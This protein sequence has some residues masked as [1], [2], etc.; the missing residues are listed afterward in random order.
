MTWKPLGLFLQPLAPRLVM[1]VEGQLDAPASRLVQPRR[2]KAVVGVIDS[3]K[4]EAAP[5]AVGAASTIY[6]APTVAWRL[7]L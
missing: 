7:A 4:F 1:T 3:N 6:R 5:T 2:K